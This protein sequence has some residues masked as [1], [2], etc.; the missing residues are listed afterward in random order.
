MSAI[1]GVWTQGAAPDPASS[2]ARVLSAQAL[3]GPHASDQ[4]DGGEVSLGRRLF[5]LLPEDKYDQQPLVGAGGRL[6]LVADLRL[7]NRQDLEAELNISGERARQLC[8]AAILLAAWERWA[9]DC[10]DHLVG[11]YAFGLWDR[12]RAAL[13]LGRDPLGHR[14]IH[15][16]RGSR[17]FA[18]AS[19]PKGL[20][21]LEEV[22]RAPDEASARDFLA[23]M[24]E[25]GT[26]T[27]FAG[28]ERVEPGCLVTVTASGLHRTRHW[29]PRRSPIKLADQ[30]E[31]AEALRAHLDQAVRAQLRGADGK[32]GAHLSG[33]LDSSAVAATAARFMAQSGGRVTGFTSVPREG[34]AGAAPTWYMSDEGPLAASVAS[35]HPNID[36]VLVRP[37]GRLQI[38]SL[39]RDYFLYDRP[40]L[41]L[42]NFNWLHEINR[43]ARDRGLTIMLT[44]AGGNLTLTYS[45]L[46]VLPELI[47]QRR[48]G[49]WLREARQIVSAGTMRWRGALF[50]SLG[51]WIPGPLWN[52]LNRLRGG[53]VED[54]GELTALNPMLSE[55]LERD[56]RMRTMG[57]DPLA[58]PSADAFSWRIAMLTYSDKG[59]YEKGDLGGW[60]VD[61][62]DPTS[63]R[64]LMEFCLNIP[65]EQF[66]S[67]GVPRSLARHALV[68]RL[69][70]AVLK[71]T[72]RGYQAADWHEAATAGRS[73]LAEQIERLRDCRPAAAALDLSRLR[74]L[75]NSWPTGGWERNEVTQP[76]RYALLRGLSVG[77]FLWRASGSNS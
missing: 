21:A 20:H 73:E 39:D 38:D 53:Y 37:T 16:H 27:F 71:E 42:C 45:G 40:L 70:A 22:P 72:R 30:D 68:D 11:C 5:R 2:C 57:V 12:D 36:H 10:F 66:I 47:A 48:P 77:H 7:D 51:P 14:P 60:G 50:F 58:R 28:V 6:V 31:Y 26:R 9:E 56:R 34:Y 4:W 19:M 24:P 1:G 49:A 46:D 41:N 44:G 74:H 59:N 63:D 65:T 18:F 32:V 33:G 15:F 55:G 61:Q 67:G 75:V 13:V 25:H 76:Y 3:Y 29:R 52:R 54:I 23:L 17:F 62:R 43:R 69:P 8:D 35:R 64:R